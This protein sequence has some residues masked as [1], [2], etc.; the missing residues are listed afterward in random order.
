MAQS[1]AP[2][3]GIIL[4]AGS[5]RRFGQ[6]KRMHRL[7]G[8]RRLLEET[9]RQAMLNVQ[10]LLVVLRAEDDIGNQVSELVNEPSLRFY[11]APDSSGGMGSSLANAIGQIDDWQA[12]LILL[13]D[14]PYIRQTTFASILAAYRPGSR[15]IIVPVTNDIQGHPVLFDRCY[16]PDLADLHGDHGARQILAAHSE[17]VIHIEVDDPGILTDIDLP[18]DIEM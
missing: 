12:V 7:P 14:M 3:G 6:D 8:G 17:Q 13:G 16:F 10:R 1:A 18:E 15:A 11:R 5:S 2:I 4:A 9:I